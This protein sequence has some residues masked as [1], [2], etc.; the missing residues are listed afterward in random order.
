[1]N[2][3]TKART[4]FAV[5]AITAMV[6]C[7]PVLFDPAG[8]VPGAERSDLW[9]SL[10]S[11]WF[12]QHSVVSGLSPFSTD[13]L[14]FPSGGSLAIADPVNALLALALVPVFGLVSSY[15]VLVVG[16]LLFA[17]WMG[18]RLAEALVPGT[19]SR[20]AAWIAGLGYQTAPVLISAVHNGTSESIGG[21]WL[22]LA[23][24]AALVAMRG[25]GPM[26]TGLAAG[27]LA[28]AAIAS[29][30]GGLCAFIGVLALAAFGD[31]TVPLRSRLTRLAPA[32]LVAALLCLPLAWLQ[33]HATTGAAN[34]VGIKGVAELALVR[35]TT[36]AADP[37]AFF[38][39]GDFRSPDF[40]FLSRY[41]EEFV[42]CVYLGWVALAGAVL[43]SVRGRARG[44]GW[45]VAA[46]IAGAL[47]SV[48]PVLVHGGQAVLLPGDRVIPLPYLVLESLPGFSSLSLLY[49]LA[50]LPALCVVLLAAR[51]LSGLGSRPRNA[52][53]AA[54][55]LVF[56]E[57]RLLSPVLGLPASS[58]ARFPSALRDL[59][60]ATSGAVMNF[61][62][63]GGRRYLYEQTLHGKPITGGLNFPNNAASR[64]V[65][66]AI[67]EGGETARSDPE[68][69]RE[70]IQRAACQQGIRYLVVHIDAMARPD[71]HELG[72]RAMHHVVPILAASPGLRIHELCPRSPIDG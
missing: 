16:H 2:E 33:H 31:G 40:R 62:V 46:G 15:N 9:N 47:L 11:L 35:R 6:I 42:H 10:W 41:G 43:A 17:G 3:R 26:R 63:V 55:A 56:G 27:A 19:S 20:G 37:L 8:T 48:G 32:L 22:P 25:G 4:L 21:G 5:Y 14:G 58:D 28:L 71:R 30:Y 60:G 1:M 24:L 52:A 68:G 18:H 36:G 45:L 13:L 12:F 54:A 66:E 53:I 69:Y 72:V 44:C 64:I 49:R 65:W 38:V 59:A 29:W 7:L 70:R 57:A 34:L 61:P 39:P 67:I 51:G 50:Q 23:M